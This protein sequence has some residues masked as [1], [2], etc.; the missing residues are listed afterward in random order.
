MFRWIS[1]TLLLLRGIVRGAG[2]E[3]HGTG[4]VV[5]RCCAVHLTHRE[6]LRGPAGRR[7]S[8]E[9]PLTLGGQ[10]VLGAVLDD[11]RHVGH[12]SVLQSHRG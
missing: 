10:P 5:N 11:Y 7:R 9:K 8:Q 3:V 12:L 1:G 6:A 2:A 4:R